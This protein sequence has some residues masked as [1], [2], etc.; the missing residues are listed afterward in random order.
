MPHTMCGVVLRC[1]ARAL[2]LL[3]ARPKDL[4]TAE[5]RDEDW[6]ANLLWLERQKCMLLAHAGTCFRSSF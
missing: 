2:N 6:Y 4:A 5:H 1:T 3:G